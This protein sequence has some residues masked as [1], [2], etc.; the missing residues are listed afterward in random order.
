MAKISHDN[1]KKIQ[2]ENT[3]D[4]AD[5]ILGDESGILTGEMLGGPLLQEKKSNS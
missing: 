5:Y 2:Q 4:P 1:D 3:S